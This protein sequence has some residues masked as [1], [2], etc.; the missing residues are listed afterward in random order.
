MGERQIFLLALL[1]SLIFSK[2]VL[3]LEQFLQFLDLRR[4]KSPKG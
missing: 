4:H 1:S 2:I 3:F